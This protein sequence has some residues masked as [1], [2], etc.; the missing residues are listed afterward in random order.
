MLDLFRQKGVTS[1]VYGTILVATIVVFVVQFRPNS[2]PKAATLRRQCAATVRG[3]CIDPK[4]QRS[5][6]RL[7]MPRGA[8]GETSMKQARGMGLT[9]LSLDALV[10]RELLIAEADRLGLSVSDKELTD[11]FLSGYIYVSTPLEKPEVGL[12]MPPGRVYAG[13]LD[14]KTKE[15]DYKVFERTIRYATGRSSSE[16][17][18]WQKRELLAAKV[19]EALTKNVT[20]GEAE[21]FQ[22]YQHDQTRSRVGYVTVPQAFLRRWAP[23]IDEKELATWRAKKENTDAVE[24]VFQQRLEQVTPHEKHLRHI[25]VAVGPEA[26]AKSRGLALTRLSE[27]A[28][29]VAHGEAFSEVARDVSDDKGSATKGG[30]VGDQTDKFVPAFKVAADALKAGEITAAVE[31]RFGFHLIVRDDASKSEAVLI[32]AKTTIARQLLLAEKLRAKAEEIASSVSKDLEAGKAAADIAIAI[33][34]PYAGMSSSV[35][36][37]AVV[38]DASLISSLDAPA[39][40]DA[41]PS[42]AAQRPI[43]A[44]GARNA[45]R[46]DDRPSGGESG[47]FGPGQEAF[48]GMTSASVG[49]VSSFVQSAAIGAVYPEALLVESGFAIVKLLERKDAE[50]NAFLKDKAAFIARYEQ[51]KRLESMA[52]YLKRARERFAA[53]IAI[54]PAY[55][56]EPSETA[57]TPTQDEGDG[58]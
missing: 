17:R 4:D 24:S 28:N 33:A 23:P 35:P 56:S 15:F 52:I 54:D 44:A 32:A 11:S 22:F 21:A 30:D 42:T 36:A 9:R 47:D 37:L 27:A 7:L 49:K 55:A 48:A 39:D 45:D 25:L 38:R 57:P 10:D 31:T 51:A 1:V 40:G 2:G 12:R 43:D 34:A 16:F 5:T 8:D 29:R 18:E 41:G 26:D 6:F 13:F 19:R 20:V 58:E 53:E 50:L 14:A 46:D 3:N